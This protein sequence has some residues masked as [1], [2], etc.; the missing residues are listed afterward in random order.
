M[1]VELKESRVLIRRSKDNSLVLIG[2]PE[3]E[4]KDTKEEEAP[5]RESHRICIKPLLSLWT[6]APCTQE[7]T[8]PS[9]DPALS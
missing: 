9:R 1:K 7:T 6:N 3:L 4:K 8:R 2:Q 5:L